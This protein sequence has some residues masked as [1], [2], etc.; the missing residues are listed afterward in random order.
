VQR[1]LTER[2]LLREWTADDAD[3]V[4]EMY[5]QWDVQRYIGLVPRVMADRREAE[6]AIARWRALGH[7][8]HGVWAVET[9]AEGRLLGT[10]LLKPIPASGDQLP[11]VPS[12]DVEIGWHFHPEAWGHGYATEAAARVLKH[13][14][15]AGLGTVVAVTN[16][17]NTPSQRVAERIGM[18]PEGLTDRYYNAT[19]E[20]F[21]ATARPLSESS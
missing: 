16:P 18:S 14:F 7:P 17:A 12:G 8:V 4:F 1:L 20:L 5:A 11:L 10:L 2:L 3:F 21:V 19:C 9:R 13:A 6:A 15:D